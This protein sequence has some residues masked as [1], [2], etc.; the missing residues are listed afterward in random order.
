MIDHYVAFSSFRHCR[1][2]TLNSR[3][4]KKRAE[5]IKEEAGDGLY[6]RGRLDHS[7]KSH[8]GGSSPF[9]LRGR[10]GKRYQDS[11]SFDDEGN[12][13]FRKA[14]MVVGNDEMTELVM[15]S[16]GSYHMTHMRDFLYDFKG[17]TVKMQ[18]GRIKHGGSKQVGFRQLGHKQVGYKKLGHKQVGFKQLGP[19]VETGVHG[20]QDEKYV[21]FKVEL[22]GAQGDHKARG[23]QVS[24][25]DAAVAQR[26]VVPGSRFQHEEKML[27]I[28]NA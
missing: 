5:G 15:D 22:Q 6:G 21:W 10:T 2:V 11:D 4:L 17:Y 19:S 3:E 7:G 12:A 25:N 26:R 13:Y 8:S 9:K 14:L 16:G 28:V 27:S 23:F 1:G 24:N 18:M 20:V